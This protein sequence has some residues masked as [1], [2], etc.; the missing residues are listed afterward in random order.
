MTQTSAIRKIVKR[1]GTVVDYDRRR[2]TAAIQ[3]ALVSTGRPSAGL[4]GA[5]AAR[6]ESALLGAYGAESIPS[7]EDIQDVVESVLMENR[8]TDV[9]RKYIIYRHQRAMARAAR[10]YDFEVTDNVSYKKI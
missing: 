10:A 2:I 8:L 7:V 9:A 1:D 4:A 6:V 5:M 3:K